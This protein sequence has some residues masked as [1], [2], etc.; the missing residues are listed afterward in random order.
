[1]RTKREG[2]RRKER[3]REIKKERERVRERY[4]CED[5]KRRIET[6]R[7][8][9]REIKGK[10]ERVVFISMKGRERVLERGRWKEIKYGERDR[11]IDKDDNNIHK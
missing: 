2:E 8:R 6:M 3:E 7:R 9:E 5:K 1:M 11:E 10:R 4:R